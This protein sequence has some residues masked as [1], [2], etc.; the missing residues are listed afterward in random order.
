MASAEARPL[1]QS[2]G[3][4]DV[5]RALPDTLARQGHTIRRLIPAYGFIDRA[6]FAPEPPELS[7]PLG[8]A[9]VPARFLSRREASGVITTLVENQELLGRDGLY[10]PPGGAVWMM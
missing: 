7:V 9:F 4:A 6:G 3:L 8:A 2:G 5:L 1:A 10:G